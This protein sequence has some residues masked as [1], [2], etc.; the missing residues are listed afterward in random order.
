MLNSIKTL[1][2]ELTGEPSEKKE[3]GEEDYRLSAAAL[4]FHVIAVDGEVEQ[5]ELDQLTQTLE[6]HYQLTPAQS[7]ELVALAREKDSEAVDLYGFTSMLKRHLDEDERRNIIELMWE[8]VYADG[9]VHEFEDN[10]IW[11]VA[12]LL[13]VSSRDRMTLKQKV[14]RRRQSQSQSD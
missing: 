5:V 2:K 3:F 9:V 8:M 6:G 13:G 7:A 12:E 4:L 11:R 10:T 14:A 1:F